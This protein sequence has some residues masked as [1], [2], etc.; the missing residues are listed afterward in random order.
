MTGAATATGCTP[1]STWSRLNKQRVAELTAVG[2][3]QPAG[4]AAVEAAKANGRWQA[5]DRVP[6][7]SK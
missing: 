7:R 2:L 3:M 5:L 6:G 4:L 1:T